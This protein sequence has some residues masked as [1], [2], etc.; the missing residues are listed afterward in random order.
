MI[1]T[2]DNM[3][4]EIYRPANCLSATDIEG[5]QRGADKYSASHPW[6]VADCDT[7]GNLRAIRM[8]RTEEDRQA[9]LAQT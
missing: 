8:F 9:H 1:F 4:D 5:L 3:P 2:D 7:A 6:I